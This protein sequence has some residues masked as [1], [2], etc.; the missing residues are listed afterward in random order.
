VIVA[1]DDQVEGIITTFDVVRWVAER[2][3]H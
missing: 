1:K 3:S 2:S